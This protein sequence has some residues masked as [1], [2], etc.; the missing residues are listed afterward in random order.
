LNISEEKNTLTSTPW[1]TLR[2]REG[3]GNWKRTVS[4]SVENSFWKRLWTYCKTYCRM[5]EKKGT[6]KP[7]F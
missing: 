1:I 5:N 7:L 4:L 3:C 2:K 6:Q